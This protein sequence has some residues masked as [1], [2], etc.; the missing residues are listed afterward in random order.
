M[1]SA[2]QRLEILLIG[3]VVLMAGAVAAIL[4]VLRP[5]SQPAYPSGTPQPLVTHAPALPTNA[6]VLGATSIPAERPT[7]APIQH[8][9]VAPA[10]TALATAQAPT[11]QTAQPS[12]SLP[13]PGGMQAHLVLPPILL[14]SWPSLLLPLGLVSIALVLMRRRRR[15][16]TYTNQTV[17]QLLAAADATTR[18]DNLKVMRGLAEQGLLTAELAAAAGIDLLTSPKKRLPKLPRMGLA[19]PRIVLPRLTLPALRLPAIRLPQVRLPRRTGRVV[20]DLSPE[21][22]SVEV[23]PAHLRDDTMSIDM[24]NAKPDAASLSDISAMHAVESGET[25]HKN[26]A[27]AADAAVPWTAEDRALAVA[28]ALAEIWAEHAAS[29]GTPIQSATIALDTSSTPGRAGAVREPPVL[30]SIDGHPDEEALT[31]ELPERIVARHPTWQSTW[32]KDRLEVVVA[33]DDAQSP[34][35]VPPIMPVLAHGRGGTTIHF[36][37]LAT[38]QHLGFYGA[39]ALGALHAALASL[40]FAQPPSD[41]ALAILDNG[42]VTPLYRDV[43]HLVPL[44]ADAHDTIDLLAQAL[45]HGAVSSVHDGALTLRPLVLVVVEPDD[46][47]LTRLSGLVARL[48]ARPT[49]PL[50]LL[51][52]Q[53]RL[54]SAGRELYALLPGL[55]TSGGQ[56]STALLPGQGAWPRPGEARLI[57]RGMRLEGRPIA[58]DEAAT[59]T[60]L[61]PLHGRRA[62]LPAV[63]WDIA[64]TIVAAPGGASL[65]IQTNTPELLDAPGELHETIP[66][67]ERREPIDESH[68]ACS[69]DIAHDSPK[70]ETP[71]AEVISPI[72]SDAPGDTRAP[73]M[74]DD[75]QRAEPPARSRRAALLFATID[76]GATAAAAALPTAPQWH[77]AEAQPRPVSASTTATTVEPIVEPD[78][79]FPIGPIPLGRVAV[80]DLMTRLVTTPA[81]VAGQANELGVTKNRLVD[82]LKGTQKVEAK[83]LAEILMAWFDLAGL[84]VEPTRPGRLRHPRALVTTDLAEIAVR[85]NAVPCPDGATVQNMWAE[86]HEE[87]N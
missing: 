44:P 13:A 36:F 83:A 54:S 63:L 4:L 5:P 74:V 42:E 52:V 56:G 67:V 50:H 79:G 19:R 40:L 37:P 30:V 10:I 24:T 39:G 69:V 1:G 61:R 2:L 81:I 60:Q 45:R 17:G 8:P 57:G 80:A 48:Q 6:P 66:A 41:L 55:I 58:L 76:A 9:A 78:N 18:T 35:S 49:A 25:E 29:R 65:H 38:W 32:R 26:N 16:M 72:P 59:A 82:L 20:A 43:A 14:A 71:F 77:E 47:L 27:P 34:I 21:S 85:L 3:L 75:T 86:S 31:R 64:A 46:P 68:A 70:G 33:A 73:N 62:G 53:E 87:N 84:L 23:A 22:M 7:T 51:I 28:H 12:S 11:A 15:Q